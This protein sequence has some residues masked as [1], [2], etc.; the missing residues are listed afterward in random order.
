MHYAHDHD[1]MELVLITSGTGNHVSAAGETPLHA[2][3]MVLLTPGVWHEY[4]DCSNLAGWDCCFGK[5][6]IY[7]DLAVATED[8]VLSR[9]LLHSRSTVMRNQP[10]FGHLDERRL[11]AAEAMLTTVPSRSGESGHPLANLG[12][13]IA[14]LG[15]FAENVRPQ[16]EALPTRSVSRSAQA[17]VQR[18]MASFHADLT[19]QWSLAEIANE[20]GV[21]QSVLSRAFRAVVGRAPIDS[22]VF[23]RMEHAA[24]L[25]LRSDLP[26]A[27]IGAQ[28]GITDANYF[29]RRFRLVLGMRPSDYRSRFQAGVT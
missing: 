2:G 25:L 24:M 16:I 14:L 18:A 11:A 20:L 22:L 23:A 17:L 3:D 15:F 4:R 26:I 1:F 21:T 28:V 6:H 12:V 13:M 10:I 8:P 29:S 9:L 7:H 19:R 5:E 27:T